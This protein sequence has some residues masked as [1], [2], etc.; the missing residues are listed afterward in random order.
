MEKAKFIV[1]AGDRPF[2]DENGN[3]RLIVTGVCVYYNNNPKINPISSFETKVVLDA[4][5]L[6]EITRFKNMTLFDVTT[7]KVKTSA[8]LDEI[9]PLKNIFIMFEAATLDDKHLKKA[10]V[11]DYKGK[12]L[13]SQISQFEQFNKKEYVASK[14]ETYKNYTPEKSK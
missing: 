2:Y 11:F 6:K 4:N 10:M 8:R 7:K 14:K 5:T 9:V 3:L 1:P 12:V 13:E